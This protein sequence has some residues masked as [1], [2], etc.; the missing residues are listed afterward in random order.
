MGFGV[1]CLVIVQ[2]ILTILQKILT[3]IPANFKIKYNYLQ[4]SKLSPIQ[5]QLLIK[6]KWQII[7]IHGYLQSQYV[8][9]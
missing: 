8:P 2:I 1:I 6:L 4:R 5:R 7:Q 3:H 9:S